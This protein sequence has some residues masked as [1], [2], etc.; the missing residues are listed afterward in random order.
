MRRSKGT[1]SRTRERKALGFPEGVGYCI[2]LP[3][4]LLASEA[5]LAMTPQCRKLVDA[6]MTEWADHGGKENG[7]LLAPYDMLEERGM[8]RQTVL[9]VVTEAKA[10]GIVEPTRG[11][12][13][14]GSRKQPSIYRLTW[15]GTP[16][17][18]TASH[19]WK[20]VKTAEEAHIRVRNALDVLQRERATKRTIR[21]D[22]AAQRATQQGAS[23]E[24]DAE[25]NVVKMERAADK[26]SPADESSRVA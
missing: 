9:D 22:R 26:A 10:L 24:S 6:L 1:L 19:E 17:G 11:R 25:N 12:R 5:W 2:P 18:L 16:D 4:D 3:R 14:H 20:S 21:E 23:A 7:N 15:L 8:R 13:S